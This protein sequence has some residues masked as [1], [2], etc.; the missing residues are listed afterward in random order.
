MNAL[1]AIEI[2][3]PYC[4]ESIDILIDASTGDREQIEDCS[5]CCRPITL[6]I[7]IDAETGID[8]TTARDDA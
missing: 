4:G 1:E 6:N 2:R 7:S 8:V 5:V 3:C